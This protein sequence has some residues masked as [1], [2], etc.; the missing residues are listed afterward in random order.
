[1]LPY[2]RKAIGCTI[3]AFSC[4]IPNILT[5]KSIPNLPTIE[6]IRPIIPPIK[7]GG[8][9]GYDNTTILNIPNINN[10]KIGNISYGID[11]FRPDRR[12]AFPMYKKDIIVGIRD[13]PT[14][15]PDK[16]IFFEDDDLY[17]IEFFYLFVYYYRVH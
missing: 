4:F 9:P 7:N 13:D 17:L 3:Q 5:G 11:D 15:N 10:I 6:N 8:I 1:M 12:Y 14:T 2:K 16:F